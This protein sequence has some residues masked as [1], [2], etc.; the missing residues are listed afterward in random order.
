MSAILDTILDARLIAIVRHKQYQYP[1]EVAQA[2]VFGGVRLLEFTLSGEGALEAITAARR[3]VRPEIRV[4]AGTVL[5]AEAAAEAVAAGA[6]FIVTPV[7]SYQVIAACQNLRVP[8]A[9]GAFTPTEIAN[10]ADAGADLVK[11]FPARLGGPKYVRDLLAPLP[12]LRLVPTGG[13]SADNAAE[14]LDAGA[15]AVAMG[16]NL[17]AEELI[18][19][20]RFGEITER[21][22][23]SVQAVAR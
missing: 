14:F 20:R 19:Q 11:L 5:S 7:L 23:K 2:L 3:A 12:N 1:A 18:A 13:V 16:G 8:I 6:E 15:V 4:G 10:A 17:V 22:K 21:A 9:C